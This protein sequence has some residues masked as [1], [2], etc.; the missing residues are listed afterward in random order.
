[1]QGELPDLPCLFLENAAEKFEV[2]PVGWQII[3]AGRGVPDS[4]PQDSR[5]CRHACRSHPFLTL[6][7]SPSDSC[8]HKNHPE[9]AEINKTCCHIIQLSVRPLA[10]GAAE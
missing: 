8:N 9:Y 5:R 6:P 1:M 2:R 10:P 7:P 4:Q 3:A